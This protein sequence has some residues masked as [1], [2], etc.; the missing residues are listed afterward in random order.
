MYNSSM[1][2]EYT[3]QNITLYQ[4]DCLSVLDGMSENSVDTIIT[5]PPYELNFMSQMQKWDSTGI[6]FQPETWAKVLK[7]CKP[8]GYLLCFGGTRTFHRI[9]CAIEDAGWEI[10]DSLMLFWVHGS[11]MPK[12][13]NI[14][15]KMASQNNEQ[16]EQWLGWNTSLK[17]SWEPILV[18]MKPPDDNKTY[19]DNAMQFG[20]AGFNIDECR[21]DYRSQADLESATPQGKCTSKN[22]GA[23]GA[24]PDA[25]RNMSRVE[26]DRPEMLGRY[27]SNLLFAHHPDCEQK[28]TRRVKGTKP[29][30]V[31]SKVDKYDGWGNITQKHG[32]VV[33][34]YEDE[35]GHETIEAW[36]CHPDCPVRMLDEQ[37]GVLK[38][39]DNC[40]ANKT[41]ANYQANSYGKRDRDANKPQVSYGDMGGASRFFYAAKAS[42]S[43][44]NTGLNGKNINKHST[45]KPLALMEYLCKLTSTPTK[46]TVLD[47]F[48]G[49]G[50]TGVACVNTG[51]KFIG[52]EKDADSY[53]IAKQRIL[54]ANKI[55][56][57]KT[58]RTFE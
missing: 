7:I 28:G 29:H 15:R 4:G 13:Q 54:H 25:G 42:R 11:G 52:I 58:V 56:K 10:K 23:I 34:K 17:P 6:S 43:E 31:F 2:P 27:P 50:T 22:S 3:S 1:E 38:S 36:N 41:A 19:V 45:V 26:F 51:R 37:T 57:H 33:N 46:G 8:C 30:K 39:G 40:Y 21:I 14:G 47:C 5:D 44:K 49:S 24:E 55:P 18:A 48:M 16:S 32:E 35:T 53:Q 12:G 20:V 9:A